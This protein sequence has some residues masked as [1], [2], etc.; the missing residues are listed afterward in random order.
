MLALGIS[1]ESD[2]ILWAVFHTGS[3]LLSAKLRAIN[4]HLHLKVSMNLVL[5]SLS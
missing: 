4:C 3:F 2:L 5:M 1:R